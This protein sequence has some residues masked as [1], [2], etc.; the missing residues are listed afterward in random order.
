MSDRAMPGAAMTPE[1]RTQMSEKGI[2]TADLT[3]GYQSDLV[4]R[5][6]FNVR[7]GCIVTLI[8]PNGCGKSTLL[9]T[10]CRNLKSRGGAV[11]L[12]GRDMAGMKSHEIA[13][14]LALVMTNQ[15]RPDL[16]TCREVI[17]TGRYPY[18]GMLGILS[19]RDKAVT[20]EVIRI[21]N[22]LDVA[23]KLFSSVSDGQRQRVML[24]RAICQEPEVLILDEPTSYLDIRYRL[25]I[26]SSIRQFA[27]E[28][29]MAVLMSL[30][31]LEIAMRIS[32][33]VIAM[34]D[35]QVQRIGAPE[36]VFTESFIR[37]LF[38]I[39]GMDTGML[40]AD[41]WFE[42]GESVF[43]G[44][45]DVKETADGR[46]AADDT[47]VPTREL[48]HAK[49]LMIQGTM[50]NA[51][52][53]FLAAGLCRIFAQ[54]G[55]KVAPFKSQNMALN[56]YVT[57]DGLEMGRA[58]AV[59]AW[60]CKIP[61]RVSMN[62][63]LLKPVDDL[64]SQ[65]IVNGKPI[66]NR[67]AAEYFARKKELIPEIRRAYDELDKE[68]DIIVVE[69]AGS[70]VE[71]N[72]KE[73]DI[74]N[75][76]LAEM[77]G[78]NVLLAG[79]IDKGGVFAQLIGTLDLMTPAE[80]A[81]VKGLI[82]NKFR[83]DRGLFEDGVE[84]LEK[85]SDK[86]VVGV[87]PFLDV[88][89]EEEDSLSSAFS[90]VYTGGLDITVVR[91]PH[92]SNFTDLD[93]FGQIPEVSVRFVTEA[94]AL[95][96][97]DLLILPGSKNTIGDLRWLKEK[98]LDEKIR[99]LAGEGVAII[100]ICGGYQMLGKSVR[101]PHETE[102]GGTEEGLGLLPV[103]TVLQKEKTRTLFTGKI[104]DAEGILAGLQGV[105][106]EG[107]E[108]HAGETVRSDGGGSIPSDMATSQEAVHP[109]TSGGTGFCRGNIYG[110][111][112]HGFFD[113]K[114]VL[115]GVL[116]AVAKKAGRTVDLSAVRDRSAYLEAQIERLAA[117][118]RE[119]LDMEKI[120]G[121]LGLERKSDTKET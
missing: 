7:P 80:R 73:D 15:V 16:M 37:E 42:D 28:K 71:L 121:I 120:Y 50:S 116:S 115:S 14:E 119:S 38:G 48:R 75:M 85:K 49:A 93:V 66:G 39:D 111:Y 83:G 25:E 92:I 105:G 89:I 60:C 64:G 76:G 55:Y 95:G 97:P 77:I 26:L 62:P 70:P 102:T 23:E 31:E 79:D 43:S 2:H 30:H 1:E 54:D 61:P 81:R 40:G 5:I 65:V 78:A 57:A 59:Q 4:Q 58:Q 41:P 47:P 82:V 87:V 108:I 3:I 52:K 36:E 112:I 118:L 33:T 63:V 56:S 69:G 9:K 110:T 44:A 6:N 45:A 94:N 51:G 96:R 109:F 68:F 106:V 46:T 18:T 20:E 113:R 72:L 74:V 91:F 34:G 17:G 100:G 84:I 99:A 11:Y 107:Y 35:G 88:R 67:K 27:K 104:E 117:G 29:N 21:T 103:E 19:D 98:G 53:S 22:T 90:E 8:G 114:E 12:G 24:A 32:D 86:D 101:D 10:L 13:K